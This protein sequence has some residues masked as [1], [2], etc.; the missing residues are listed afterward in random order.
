MFLNCARMVEIGYITISTILTQLIF[1][2]SM[3]FFFKFYMKSYLN[4]NF[5]A[6]EVQYMQMNI[7]NIKCIPIRPKKIIALSFFLSQMSE[8]I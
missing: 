4:P 2:Y 7:K 8:I 6:T 5:K 1:F 3:F